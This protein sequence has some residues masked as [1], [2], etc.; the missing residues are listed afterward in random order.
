VSFVVIL[1]QLSEQAP[2]HLMGTQWQVT[3]YLVWAAVIYA[4]IGTWLTHLV[5]RALIWLNF[6]QQR[7]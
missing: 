5:G 2:L 6:Y 4:A 7:Y 1:W 3:G